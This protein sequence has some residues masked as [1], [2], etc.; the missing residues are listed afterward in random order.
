MRIQDH[1][2]NQMGLVSSHA[3]S[4]LGAYFLPDSKT[5]IIKLRNPWGNDV[6]I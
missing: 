6:T 2:L 4:L 3:Y 1:T 5:K